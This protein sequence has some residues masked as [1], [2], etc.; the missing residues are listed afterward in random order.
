MPISWPESSSALELKVFISCLAFP[1]VPDILKL[2]NGKVT[3]QKHHN[4]PTS[5][6]EHHL[7]TIQISPIGSRIGGRA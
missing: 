7:Y 6:A 1:V 5:R 2:I 4:H 3:G